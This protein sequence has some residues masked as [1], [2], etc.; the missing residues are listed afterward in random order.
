MR[1]HARAGLALATAG[2][3]LALAI[4]LRAERLA[5]DAAAPGL[6]FVVDVPE[7]A[8]YAPIAIRVP[9]D[10]AAEAAAALARAGGDAA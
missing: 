9:E 8:A 4:G 1:D 3:A 2:V 7:L 10:R 5:G 6:V